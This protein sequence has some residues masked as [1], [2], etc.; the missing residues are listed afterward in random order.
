MIGLG[1]MGKRRIR[2]LKEYEKIRI[3]GIES[4]AKR[5]EEAAREWGI[6]TYADIEA[7]GEMSDGGCAFVC[8]PPLSHAAVISAC[9]QKKLNVFTEINLVDDGYEENIKTAREKN[10]VLFLSST[11][12][13]R[14]EVEFITGRVKQT[15]RPVSYLYHVGQYL[16]DWHP[17]ESYQDFFV[18]DVRTNG[19][20]EIFAIELPW[21]VT[22]FG[23]I[24]K[25]SVLK[26]KNASLHVNYND[27]YLIQIQHEN[28]TMGSF[29]V[30]VV[31]RKAVRRLEIYGEDLYLTWNG[32][33]DSVVEY[34]VIAR[35]S[36][37]VAMQKDEHNE[38]YAAF[39]TED[40]Y[41]K[42]IAAFWQA[43]YKRDRKSRWDFEQDRNV[44]HVIDQI[45]GETE[46]EK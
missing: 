46:W 43:V 20:R 9:L 37:K 38:S 6:E 44:L 11:F 34:D 28:G 32:T 14:P 21:L 3:I 12:L 17:W 30:D 33:P 42:E 1:S 36:F 27:T 15:S 4:N 24:R 45:E 26:G 7:A 23:A 35:K 29:A 2:L 18:G 25:I 39:I 10:L 31:S 5:R 41:R 8:T 22:C 19:C 16:P 40:A 13:Y